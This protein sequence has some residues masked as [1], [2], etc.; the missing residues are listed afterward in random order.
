MEAPGLGPENL[1]VLSLSCDL[2]PR[3]TL[4]SADPL[5][6]SAREEATAAETSLSTAYIIQLK[7]ITSGKDVKSIPPKSSGFAS[8]D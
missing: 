5:G 3:W 4:R 7:V 8:I 2:G 1:C 6:T